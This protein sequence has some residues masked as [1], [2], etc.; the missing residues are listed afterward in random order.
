MRAK[1]EGSAS[2]EA[3]ERGVAMRGLSIVLC[4]PSLA[5]SDS[6]AP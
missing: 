4:G 5:F 1:A 3:E 6:E 2:D